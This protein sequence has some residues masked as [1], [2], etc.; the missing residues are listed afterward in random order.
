[1][2][3]ILEK[4]KDVIRSSNIDL[5]KVEIEETDENI[6]RQSGDSDD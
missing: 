2:D 3:Y 4:K 6:E 1:M 5:W